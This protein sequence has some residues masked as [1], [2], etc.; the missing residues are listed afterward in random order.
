LNPPVTH[1]LSSVSTSPPF[2]NSSPP[3]A[4]PATS[5]VPPT[6]FRGSW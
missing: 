5:G 3:R 6:S 4:P 1:L 2:N